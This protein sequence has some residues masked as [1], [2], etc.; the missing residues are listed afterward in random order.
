MYLG[1]IIM[2]LATP[3]ALGSYYGLIPFLPLPVLLGYRIKNEEEV[4]TREL[5]GYKE[6]KEKTRY[7]LIPYVW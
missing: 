3:L 4:L 2:F 6:Y 1:V 5:P 7:R